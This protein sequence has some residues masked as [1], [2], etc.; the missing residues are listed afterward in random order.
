MLSFSGKPTPLAEDEDEEAEGDRLSFE[1]TMFDR[2]QRKVGV[3]G[4]VPLEVVGG[5]DDPLQPVT[6]DET[7][8]QNRTLT[9]RV[10]ESDN[11]SL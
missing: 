3:A 11:S 7:G 8:S 10:A 5:D 2:Q 1:L 6:S 4:S 9:C